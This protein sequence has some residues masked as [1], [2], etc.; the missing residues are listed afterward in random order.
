M[1][2]KEW[3]DYYALLELYDPTSRTGEGP[4][5]T[6]EEIKAARDLQLRAWHPDKFRSGS[7]AWKRANERSKRINEAYE[8]LCDPERKKAYDGE[9]LGRNP[10]F[11]EEKDTGIPPPEVEVKETVG[12]RVRPAEPK[13]KAVGIPRKRAIR[14]WPLL[15]VIPLLVL[16]IYVLNR[17]SARVGY[18]SGTPGDSTEYLEAGLAHLQAG[19]LD[20]AIAELK[21]ATQADP[22]SIEAHFRLGN[23]YAQQGLLKEAA[24]AFQQV[25]TL[26]PNNADAHSNLGVVYYQQG[27]LDQAVE[28]FEKARD[29]MPKDAEIHYNLASSYIQSG[30]LDE[31]AAELKAAKDLNPDLP[32]VWYGLGTLYALQDQKAEAIE[33]FEHFLELG[34]DD[35]RAI[36]EAKR[37][38][39]LLRGK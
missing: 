39:E 27:Q 17:A 14:W 12:V 28:Q 3:I 5:S 7:E 32:L 13:D 2:Q 24:Q 30:R 9:W 36:S 26:D 18:G 16:A 37:Q 35:P 19:D 11:R 15:A 23:A 1:V 34:S 21:A 38:L 10:W 8:V 20:E 22:S 29:L 6:Q 4:S 33:A 25:L 31:A